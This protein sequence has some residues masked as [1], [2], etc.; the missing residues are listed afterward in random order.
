M[1]V[2]SDGHP[3]RAHGQ[4]RLLLHSDCEFDAMEWDC[5]RRGAHTEHTMCM[6]ERHAIS[7][8]TDSVCMP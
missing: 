1:P 7:M 4:F 8:C 5:E 2:G 3:E 6:Q